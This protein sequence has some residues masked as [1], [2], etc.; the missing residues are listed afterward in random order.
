MTDLSVWSDEE[1]R[2]R[3]RRRR[4]NSRGKGALA[5]IIALLLVVA[6]L[7]GGALFAMGGLH[8][9]KD[10]LSSSS[11]P[12]YPGPGQGDVLIEVKSGQT[13]ADVAKT[14][15]AKDV[16]KSVVELHGGSVSAHS[17]GPGRGSEFVIRLPRAP[18]EAQSSAI[19]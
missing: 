6:V 14:L 12:D 8:K 13:A 3:R 19:G 1:T 16:V 4:K 9:L 2:P 15:V 5:V 10:A 17:D 7:G 18:L 11:A